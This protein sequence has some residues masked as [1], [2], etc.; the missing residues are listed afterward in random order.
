[1]K[2]KLFKAISVVLIAT[3]SVAPAISYACTSFILK[4]KDGSYVY[5]RTIEYGYVIPMKVALTPRSHQ[6]KGTGPDGVAGSGLAWNGKYAF[7]GLRAYDMDIIGDGMNEKGL[8]GSMQNLPVAALYQ[9]PTG[10]DAKNSIASYQVIAYVLSNF[11]NTDEIKAGLSK[12]FVNNSKFTQWGNDVVRQHY[13]FHDVNGKSIVVEYVKGQMNIYDNPIGALANEPPFD[14]QMMNL[15]NYLNL[16]P[17]EIGT[18]VIDGVPLKPRSAGSGLHGLPGDFM[19]QSRFLRAVQFSQAADEYSPNVD[20]VKMAWHL[21]NMFD[22]PPGSVL[23]SATPDAKG[24]YGSDYTQYTTVADPKKLT[25]YARY[26]GGSDIF[27]FNMNDYDLNA[28]E[29]RQWD[30]ESTSSYKKM[31]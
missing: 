8:T 26:F 6:F 1:M 19:S 2:M 23:G 11:A 18:K 31:K 14:W 22:I 13:S 15:E 25:Y 28:K 10:N 7:M 29:V 27:A 30:N 5:A 21:I 4:N 12:I 24:S 3:F 16:S 20:K 9:N 17:V